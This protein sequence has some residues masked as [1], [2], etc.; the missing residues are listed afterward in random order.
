VH[1]CEPSFQLVMAV[2]GVIQKQQGSELLASTSTLAIDHV[3]CFPP[4]SLVA[5][6]PFKPQIHISSVTQNTASYYLLKGPFSTLLH[7]SRVQ[8]AKT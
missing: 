8:V 6:A 7:H 2:N 1:E 3:C 4:A 5:T